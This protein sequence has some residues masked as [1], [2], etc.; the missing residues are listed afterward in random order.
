M[1]KFSIIKKGSASNVRAV[2][3]PTFSGAYMSSG[4][5]DFREIASPEPID[6]KVGDYVYYPRTGKNYTLYEMPQMKKEARWGVYG[7][8]YVYSN[9]QFFDDSKDFE[10]CPFRDI[11]LGDNQIHFSTQPVISVFDNVPGIAERIQACLN[12]MYPDTWTVVVATVAM[13][14]PQE[15]VNLMNEDREFS[16][17]G[18]SVKDALQKIYDT[19]PDVGWIY[20]V[21]S[22]ENILIIGGAGLEATDGAFLYGK[23][24]GLNSITRNVANAGELANRLYVYGSSK[25]MQPSWYRGQNI[26]DA[27]SVDIQNLMIPIANW[28]LTDGLP[29]ARKAYVEDATSVS[30]RGVRPKIVYFDGSADLPEIYPTLQGATIGDVRAAMQS[31]DIYY[32]SA[33]WDDADRVDEIHAAVQIADDGYAGNDNSDRIAQ[34]Y[35]TFT[36]QTISR[37]I[38]SGG[39][40]LPIQLATA[41]LTVPSSGVFNLASQFA[42]QGR[43][44]DGGAFSAAFV[45]VRLTAGTNTWSARVDLSRDTG[46]NTWILGGWFVSPQGVSLSAG[47]NITITAIL[48]LTRTTSGTE[49]TANVSITGG[50][51]S[52]SIQKYR[53]TTFEVT[54]PQVGFDINE[55]AALGDGMT[56]FMRSGDCAGRSFK[57][58]DCRYDSTSDSWILQLARS[59]D[60]SIGCWFPNSSYQIASGDQFVILDIAMPRIYVNM[61]ENRLLAAANNLLADTATERWQYIPEIDAKFMIQTGRILTPGEYMLISDNEVIDAVPDDVVYY[62][63][64]GG[65]YYKTIN[66]QRI[67]VGGTAVIEK[68]LIDSLTIAEGDGPIPTY[69][70][71]LRDRKRTMF[72]ENG[73]VSGIS[74]HSVTSS[75][76]TQQAVSDSFFE[77]ASDGVSVKLKDNYMG[78]WAEGYMSAGGQNNNSGG[79]GSSVSVHPYSDLSDSAA[80]AP[81]GTS[82]TFNAYT[83]WSIWRLATQADSKSTEAI[84]KA[85]TANGNATTAYN[86]AV[87]AMSMAGS[88]RAVAEEARTNAGTALSEASSKLPL[89]G[90]TM[91]GDILPNDNTVDLGSASAIWGNIYG[92][93]ILLGALSPISGGVMSVGG[94]LRPSSN[95]ALDLGSTGRKWRA[96][97]VNTVYAD[98]M[99]LSGPATIDGGVSATGDGYFGG[100]LEV[101]DGMTVRG[102]ASLASATF[103]GKAVFNG[104]VEGIPTR[105]WYNIQVRK[106]FADTKPYTFTGHLDV[107]I[108]NYIADL[109][110]YANYRILLMR[111]KRGS[112]KSPYW[113]IPFIS[114]IAQSGQQAP[115]GLGSLIYTDDTWWRIHGNS[116]NYFFSEAGDTFS[117]VLPMGVKQMGQGGQWVWKNNSN[118]KQRFGCAIFKHTGKGNSGWERISNIAVVELYLCQSRT[119]ATNPSYLLSLIGNE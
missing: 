94:N 67:V 25:N 86:N 93:N 12:D 81:A 62:N 28:G 110:D 33:A 57:I 49:Q 32:P 71:T 46:D 30:D 51:T 54:I 108:E 2:G 65:G 35:T 117:D 88:A 102:S 109:L 89:A 48:N 106:V 26:K 84:T 75:D 18:G 23:G 38:A 27:S 70:V 16:I 87:S 105:E 74:E 43:V 20:K 47:A 104:G 10:L 50:G 99:E 40:I 97:Y 37:T 68:V 92:A 119:T 80:F 59:V 82:D 76:T 4:V 79:G 14:A 36:P 17:S 69:K 58:L 112:K 19:W 111:W 98:E 72:T 66:G 45:E 103:S 100:S 7:A 3:Y 85:N 63:Q 42:V 13:G 64:Q 115:I 6:F 15:L 61:A 53:P 83:V 5:L 95:N 52:L 91:T 44:N 9:V 34:D 118:K 29:D 107:V 77:L 39:V 101:R 8:S 90:G 21:E 78:L 73:N 56:I 24:K 31:T 41:S 60:E 96:I 22:G 1:A 55:Q 113:H 116:N 114:G 11:V